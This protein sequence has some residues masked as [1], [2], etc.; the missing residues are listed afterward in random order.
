MT[1][2]VRAA[3]SAADRE[4]CFAI[5]LAVSVDEQGVP[6]EAELDGHEPTATHL[7]RPPGLTR[8]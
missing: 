2:H 6:A 8:N 7:R 4:A 5:R 1:I 3:S